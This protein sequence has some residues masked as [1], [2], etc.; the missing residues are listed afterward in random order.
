VSWPIG[1]TACA[2]GQKDGKNVEW[3]RRSATSST[4]ADPPRPAAATGWLDR[5]GLRHVAARAGQ[6]K[7]AEW[8]EWMEGIRDEQCKLR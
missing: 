1:A 5:G 8:A 2:A 4:A 6:G 3:L 7:N